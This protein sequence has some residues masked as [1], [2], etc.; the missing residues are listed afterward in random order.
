MFGVI[1]ASSIWGHVE[2]FVRN[3]KEFRFYSERNKGDVF[4]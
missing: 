2:F 4:Q 1:G 3:A